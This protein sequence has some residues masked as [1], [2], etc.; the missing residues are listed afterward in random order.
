MRGDMGAGR[1]D[2]TQ[3]EARADQAGKAGAAG[4]GGAALA[5]LAGLLGAVVGAGLSRRS[6]AGRGWRIAIQR[7]EQRRDGGF[8]EQRAGARIEDRY[9][10]G[11]YRG[12]HEQPGAATTPGTLPREPGSSTDPYHH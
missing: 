4:L 6:R 11:A 10:E 8:A 5:S 7:G 2:R 1:V 9:G 12:V 3:G